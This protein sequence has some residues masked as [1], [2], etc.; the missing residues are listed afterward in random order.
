MYQKNYHIHFVGI[1]GIGMSGIAELCIKGLPAILIPFPH[2][3]DDH[4][5]FNAKALE[6]Q[7]AAV[8]IKDKDLTGQTLKA[9]LEELIKD[10]NRLK[11]MGKAMK[12]IA[13]PDAD[14]KIA[15]HILNTI[16]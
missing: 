9:C 2:A 14:K 7:D 6:K 10:S 3:A 8:M 5:T 15:T 16:G 1:G 13:M 4:Q 11:S 12:Q